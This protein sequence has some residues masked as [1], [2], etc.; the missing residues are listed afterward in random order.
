MIPKP[1]V[2]QFPPIRYADDAWEKLSEVA[3]II[4][5]TVASR[6]ELIELLHGEYS[7]IVAIGRGYL[8]GKQ[9][10][11]FD[12]DLIGHF[13]NTLKFI[14]HQGAGYDQ[15]DVTE[16]TKRGIQLANAPDIV[17]NAT[18]DTALFLL[19]GAMRNFEEGR[20]NLRNDEWPTKGFA[21]GAQPGFTPDDKVLG[22][23]GMGGIGR[24]LCKRVRPLGFKKIVYYN[25]S[26]LSEALELGCQYLPLEELLKCADVVSIH[27]PLNESTKHLLN[28]D[29]FHLMKDGVIIINTARGS[30]IEEQALLRC[31]KTGKVARV[32][33]DVFENEP[34]VS[35]ELLELPNVLALPHMGTQAIQTVKKMEECV[36]DNIYAGIHTGKVLNLVCEQRF[37]F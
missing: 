36:V 24:T 37:R 16:L 20:R 10:G 35:N 27:C 7:D 19:L 5:V 2:L 14:A 31:L 11:R 1:K 6:Q 29:R 21:A 3:E 26:P 30:V 23:I 33:L 17:N 28:K 22:I 15:I 12:R 18:A 25:R 4:P 9:V 8:T 34:H 32:G 13:P